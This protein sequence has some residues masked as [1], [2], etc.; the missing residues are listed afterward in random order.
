MA[1]EQDAVALNE[2]QSAR[3]ESEEAHRVKIEDLAKLE[4]AISMVMAGLDVSLG[5]VLPEMLVAKVR[6]LP[7]VIRE[8][9]LS[10]AQR[11]VHRVLAMLESH[12]QGLDRMELSGGRA[13]GISDTQCNELERDCTSFT[14]D[15]ANATLKDLELLPHNT[16]EDPVSPEPSNKLYH[17]LFHV[18]IRTDHNIT[19]HIVE[20][21]FELHY[22]STVPKRPRMTVVTRSLP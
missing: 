18:M 4:R 22:N 7:D 20:N 21:L 6:R 16:P 15:M 14:R 13:P 8:L 9:E 11:V 19:N 3:H 12:Y 2:A 1:R 5:P 10:A 17:F